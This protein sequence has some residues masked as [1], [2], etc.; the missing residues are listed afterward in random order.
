MRPPDIIWISRTCISICLY[1]KG[2]ML[3]LLL[4][5]FCYHLCFNRNIGQPRCQQSFIRASALHW[6]CFTQHRFRK[7][8]QISTEKWWLSAGERQLRH[9]FCLDQ[10]FYKFIMLILFC[11]P[12]FPVLH[13]Y[14]VFIYGLF[15]SFRLYLKKNR[16]NF[17]LP[18]PPSPPPNHI[19]VSF[20]FSRSC[21]SLIVLIIHTTKEQSVF[22]GSFFQTDL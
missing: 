18:S 9:Q 13:V 8:L 16:H 4:L 7:F 21:Y 14:H 1:I 11:Q 12:L 17:L 5:F 19:N 3:Q 2:I 15:I 22:F 10:Y 20:G 6:I